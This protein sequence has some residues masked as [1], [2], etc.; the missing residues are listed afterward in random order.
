VA[1]TNIVASPIEVFLGSAGG[2]YGYEYFTLDYIT[3]K[4]NINITGER[5]LDWG[6]IYAIKRL[7]EQIIT[8]GDNGII[9]LSMADGSR[10]IHKLGL[11]GKDAISGNESVH[12]FVDTEGHLWSL[13]DSLNMLDYSEYLAGL[14]NP[15]LSYDVE[16][17]LLY[18]CDGSIGYV[19]SPATGSLGKSPTNITGIGTQKGVLYVTSPSTLSVP[20][21]EI[22][23]DIYDFG[24]REGKFI[25]SVK[26]ATNT[27]K[28]LSVAIDYRSDEAADFSQT[29]WHVVDKEGRAFFPCYGVEFRFHVK[30]NAYEYF[31]LDYITIKGNINVTGERP[32]DWEEVYVV[33]RLGERVVTYGDGGVIVLSLADGSQTVYELGLKGKN[34]IAGNEGVH[35]FVDIEGCLWSLGGSLEKLDYSE[36][37]STLINPVLSYD[38]EN[39]LLYICDGTSGYIYSPK[40]RS[41][42]RGATNIT[43]I[44]SQD[45]T[46][47]VVA[48]AATVIPVFEI[49]T[50]IY[51]FGIR[52]AKVI[53][54]L[55]IG[56]NTTKTLSVSVD[57]RLSM[58]SDFIQSD[59]HVVGSDGK[60]FFP[61]YGYE[62]RF[63]IKSD[64]YEYFELDYI[65]VEGNV[66][67][68]GERPLDWKSI[69]KIKRLNNQI[70]TYG[71][72][73]IIVL[74][75]A[76]KP[77]V[78][79]SIELK[80]KDAL[81]GTDSVHYFIDTEGQL[82]SLSDTLKLLDYSEY[83]SPMGSN[84]VM[85]YDVETD[86]IY[87][88]DGTLGY[89]YSPKS[90]SL[91]RGPTNITGIGTQ[92]GVLY[93]L[94][95]AV[96]V[97]DP[98]EI[99]TDIYDL[100]TRSNK[101]IFSLDFGTDLTVGLYA[102]V[103]YRRDI[104]GA[105]A[106]TPWSLVSTKGHVNIIAFGQEFRIRAKTLAY[107][108]FELDYVRINGMAHAS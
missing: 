28:I 56:T 16:S 99:C 26:L 95:P 21:F 17:N 105:F 83:L 58:A 50:D 7:G 39:D 97:S 19:Y 25:T 36:Y 31:E 96:I 60:V 55:K 40:S 34:A 42:G 71:D 80:S 98:F 86:L 62:F 81:A 15:V 27:T 9:A 103:D 1:D 74:S 22:C 77:Q 88:C 102:A 11:K 89:V 33:K 93:V 82:W 14:I 41:L 108:Y 32:L 37:L 3:V 59:W 24:I 5:P 68:V 107:S 8:Y 85:S 52:E 18:I 49:C 54:S 94:S 78:I 46:L 79:H 64:A 70:V 106:T 61:C 100:G 23:T 10:T 84:L 72:G 45:G 48:P 57:Y 63:R 73:G 101:T 92:G 51:D 76:D 44:S 87:I 67:I 66:N 43:G 30:A 35:Y 13:S 4:G 6:S 65:T 2:Y 69:Y 47:Y 29:A 91:G 53:T 104:A 12:Y 90:G 20:V 38:A 75:M